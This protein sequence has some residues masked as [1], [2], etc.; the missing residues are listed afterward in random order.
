MVNPEAHT[1]ANGKLDAV[2]WHKSL[3]TAD[4][5]RG[6]SSIPDREIDEEALSDRARVLYFKYHV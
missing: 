2:A 1:P 6:K 4:R 3:I 5:Y